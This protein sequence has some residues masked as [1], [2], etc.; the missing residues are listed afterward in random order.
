MY[1]CL[2]HI[3]KAALTLSH[4]I[5]VRGFS[6]NYVM[7][8]KEKLLLAENTIVALHIVKN[9]ISLLSVKK[10]PEIVLKFDK[11]LV[12]KFHFVDL[13]PFKCLMLLH[14]IHS[15]QII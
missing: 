8:G 6:V 7:L 3:A 1:E 9:T 15:A 5:P 2:T 10:C 13:D 11:N 14:N 4:A 12:L